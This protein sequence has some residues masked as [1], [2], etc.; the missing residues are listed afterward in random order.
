MR[1]L[2]FCA[3]L[4]LAACASVPPPQ[5]P[6]PAPAPQTEAPPPARPAPPRGGYYKD[7]GPGENPP[8]NLAEIPDA[9]PK[10]ERLIQAANRPYTVFGQ[11]YEPLRQVQPFQQ[12]GMA[13][14]YGRRF[15]GQK[16]S[17]GEP[18]DMYAMTAAH[19]TLPI[20]SYARVTNLANGRSVVVRIN[21]R[22]PFHSER[23]IDLSYTAAYKLGYAAAGSARVEVQSILPDE[24]AQT[25]ATPAPAQTAATS[26]PAQTAATPAAVQGPAGNAVYLQL[27][28]FSSRANAEELRA[29]IAARL[30]SLAE[31]IQVLSV[32]NLWRLH[33]GPYA[34]REAARTIGERIESELNLK[35]LL[36]VR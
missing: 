1:R 16:T 30:A 4:A 25:A 27:G 23:I 21:D 24:P 19:P 22:G 20:P 6:E 31:S 18:Y 13:S 7:D 26:A 33:V 9:Q 28:A 34:S 17:S 3:L 15:H 32:G 5:E 36:V 35:P 29:R 12:T 11:S 14:W 2:A 10:P 8:A